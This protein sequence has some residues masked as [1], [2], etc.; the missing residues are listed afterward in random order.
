MIKRQMII[1]TIL[2]GILLVVLTFNVQAKDKKIYDVPMDYDQ[3]E[4]LLEIC[5]EYKVDPKL[6][7]AI[8]MT[9]SEFKADV[10][11]DANDYGL[12]QINKVNHKW[13]S[14]ELGVTDFLDPIQNIK[15]GVYIVSSY[16]SEYPDV[17]QLL[18]IYNMGE[19][20]AKKLFKQGIYKSNYSK[21]V[22]ENFTNIKFIKEIK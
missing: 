8:I 6:I 3:Q 19:S 9:E 1:L 20:G 7:L 16:I 21:K 4:K 22:M 17:H 10:I 15:A 13:L 2:S 18:M 14:E 12:M 11:S 5:E